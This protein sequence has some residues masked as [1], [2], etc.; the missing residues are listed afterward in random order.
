[1]KQ[2]RPP[3]EYSPAAHS[4][5]S[6]GA[7]MQLVVIR[8][9]QAGREQATNECVVTEKP[10]NATVQQ[11]QHASAVRQMPRMLCYAMLR[12]CAAH[13][14]GNSANS[15]CWRYQAPP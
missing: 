7:M 2:A 15:R 11:G 5:V 3:R 14:P 9:L 6:R 13:L 4:Q 8:M 10:H 1:M 12:R